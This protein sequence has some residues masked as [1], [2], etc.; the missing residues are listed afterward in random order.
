MDELLPLLALKARAW[1]GCCISKFDVGAAALGASGAVYLGTN[2][3]L[4]SGQQLQQT[5]HAEQFVVANAHHNR[6]SGLRLLATN[7]PPC[8]HCRQFL[9]ELYDADALRVHVGT[10]PSMLPLPALLLSLAPALLLLPLAP[11]LL[12]ALLLPVP[13]PLPH[14][15][16]LSV[17]LAVSRQ[18][19]AAAKW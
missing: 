17:E 4:E 15:E 2:V 9:N 12:W 6:E 18:A 19:N 16:L 1:S 8:G 7:V 11:A 14:A 13:L 5:V 10:H 3:E